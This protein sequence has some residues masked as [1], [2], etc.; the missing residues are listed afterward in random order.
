MIVVYAMTKNL[1][2]YFR[3]TLRS[4]LEHNN[5]EK[6]YILAETDTLLYD[7]PDVC[8]VINVSGY[9]KLFREDGP[10]F[11]SQF[12]W[13]AMMRAMYAEILPVDRVIQLDIDTIICDSLEPIW[14]IDLTGKWFA[15]C[16]EYLSRYR[17]FGDTYYNIGVCVFNLQ[18][19]REDG[20]LPV[21]VSLL[22]TAPLFCVE[23]D[24]WNYFGLKADRIAQLPVR[25]NETFC[26]GTTD[27]PAVVHYAGYPDWTNNRTMPRV[28]YLDRYR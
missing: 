12:T 21:I 5:P 2:P 26:C 27:N 20:V 14:E 4:L 28:E 23:Q 3:P 8:E 11:R 6:V 9:K 18:Q 17:P 10:N 16:P 22:N 13:M 24:A 25:Y 15:A 19:I 7:L 1:Y